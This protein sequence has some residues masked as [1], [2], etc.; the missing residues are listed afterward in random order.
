MSIKDGIIESY[1]EAKHLC[2]LSKKFPDIVFKGSEG[3]LSDGYNKTSLGIQKIIDIALKNKK[4]YVVC[5]GT[6]TNLA[7]AI[8]Q[9]P[10][11]IS[12]LEVVWIGTRNLIV[13]KFDDSNYV[14]DK[15]AFEEIKTTSFNA[16]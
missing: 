4:T 6:L 5:L 8:R 9:N 15:L 7:L 16:L 11:I 1:F 12:K 2:R 3:Y 14:K 13:D 10:S